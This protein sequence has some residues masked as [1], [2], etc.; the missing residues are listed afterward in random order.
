MTTK[1]FC[2]YLNAFWDFKFLW[3]QNFFRVYSPVLLVSFGFGL[4]VFP[5]CSIRICLF[6]IFL[7]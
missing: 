2:A 6:P 3:V 4:L 1:K 7:N 5:E